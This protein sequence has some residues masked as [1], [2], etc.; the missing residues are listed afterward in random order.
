MKTTVGLLG[1]TSFLCRHLF[2][3]CFVCV[4]EFLLFLTQEKHQHETR[5]QRE[6][7]IKTSID[8]SWTTFIVIPQLFWDFK[9]LNFTCSC[10]ENRPEEVSSSRSSEVL[11]Q[12]CHPIC[13]SHVLL[14]D[15]S[16]R[17]FM[18][19]QDFSTAI[20]IGSAMIQEDLRGQDDRNHAVD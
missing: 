11:R 8:L 15:V 14:T 5:H 16:S 19:V 10:N 7:L 12:S 2:D 3:D 6:D 13:I 17:L 9:I 4:A 1:F 18:S 20:T